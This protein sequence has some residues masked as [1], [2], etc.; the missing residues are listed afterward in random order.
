MEEF[1]DYYTVLGINEKTSITDVEKAFRK[2]VME[3]RP[4]INLDNE[5]REK[6]ELIKQAREVL[7][8]TFKRS[9]Y[10]LRCNDYYF[11]K[12]FN[13]LDFKFNNTTSDIEKIIRDTE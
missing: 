9:S 5:T 4:D 1:I 8:D 12:M 7:T 3:I 10:N 2:K 6:F 11:S 13:R